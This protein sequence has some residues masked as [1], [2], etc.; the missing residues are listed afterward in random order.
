MPTQRGFLKIVSRS[1]V[2]CPPGLIACDEHPDGILRH[3]RRFGR[4]A[5][6]GRDSAISRLDFTAPS[7][8]AYTG[9]KRERVVI[10]LSLFRH[11]QS[12][13]KSTHAIHGEHFV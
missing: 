5:R 12:I 8:H 13:Q 7:R 11:R 2:K 3:L 1:P 6:S 9:L 4:R 10:G